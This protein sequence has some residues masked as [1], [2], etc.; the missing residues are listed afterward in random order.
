MSNT[1][2]ASANANIVG[3][4]T[5]TKKCLKCRGIYKYVNL[6][7]RKCVKCK[8]CFMY[9]NKCNIY[10]IKCDPE[11]SYNAMLFKGFLK[12]AFQFF[13]S[14]RDRYPNK[15]WEIIKRLNSCDFNI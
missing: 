7:C 13:E 4:V 2:R 14:I 5:A 9:I 12:N 15:V 1:P 8:V 6:Y 10:C 3:N 11:M